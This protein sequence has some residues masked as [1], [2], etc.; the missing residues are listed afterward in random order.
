MEFCHRAPTFGDAGTLSIKLKIILDGLQDPLT[1]PE[2]T[3]EALRFSHSAIRLDST[4]GKF[5]CPPGS[6]RMWKRPG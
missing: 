4:L 6:I 3:R 1:V 2:L 5:G